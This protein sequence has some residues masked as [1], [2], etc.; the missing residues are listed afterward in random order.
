[1]TEGL[2]FEPADDEDREPGCQ[3][4]PALR[5]EAGDVHDL[6]WVLRVVQ[7]VDRWL[8]DAAPP[9]YRDNP[10][11]NRWRRLAAGPASE[12]QEAVDALNLATG[13]N[14]R[15]GVAGT[16]D[17][18]LMELGDTVSAALFA[19]QSITKDTGLTWQWVLAAL[20]KALSRIPE[21]ERSGVQPGARDDDELPPV[22]VPGDV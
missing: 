15:K 9:E 13:G 8:D 17:D 21:A 7:V 22:M 1:M 19:I 14:P 3:Q 5:D 6:A 11:A 18:V 16:E 4:H 2:G 20:A 10:L 12:G